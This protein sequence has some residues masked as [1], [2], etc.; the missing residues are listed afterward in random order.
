MKAL[1]LTAVILVGPVITAAIYSPIYQSQ[2]SSHR[3]VGLKGANQYR[4]HLSPADW[5]RANR[6]HNC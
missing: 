5:R 6:K 2:T 4:Q 1:I 3:V